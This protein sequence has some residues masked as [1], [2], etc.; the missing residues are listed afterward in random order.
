MLR[1]AFAHGLEG[2][3]IVAASVAPG[4][5][6][7]GNQPCVG[8]VQCLEQLGDVLAGGLNEHIGS[9]NE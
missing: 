1:V 9:A 6:V 2:R 8:I 7:T 5:A 4:G 3:V